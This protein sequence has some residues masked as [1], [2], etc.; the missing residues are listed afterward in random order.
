[1]R[2]GFDEDSL[3]S[4]SSDLN[5]EA[6]TEVDAAQKFTKR[7][8]NQAGRNYRVFY[9]KDE[10]MAYL[11][12]MW[13]DQVRKPSDVIRS[14][15]PSIFSQSGCCFAGEAEFFVVIPGTNIFK[16]IGYYKFER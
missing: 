15:F 9:L 6:D 5:Q 4:K 16:K 11:H 8:F 13:F 1:M 2:T 14:D 7:Y 10:R 12:R 3:E